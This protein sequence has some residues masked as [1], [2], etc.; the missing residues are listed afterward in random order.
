MIA[1]VIDRTKLQEIEAGTRTVH[2]LS[3]SDFWHKRLYGRH[4]GVIKFLSGHSC[5]AFEIVRI[6]YMT[7]YEV[8]VNCDSADAVI[9]TEKCFAVYLGGGGA[10]SGTGRWICLGV[11]VA[12][13]HNKRIE[14]LGLFEIETIRKEIAKGP[15]F[16]TL[17][18]AATTLK[19]HY[20]TMYRLV[21]IGEID[22]SLVAG[23]WRIPANALQSYL[24]KRHPFNMEDK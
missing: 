12:I 20:I 14:Q 23:C 24:E 5:K 4:H 17:K 3:D 10:L 6:E 19:V 9:P 13:E 16:Y 15:E 7:P 22:A 1:T 8:R 18:E 2:Y 11:I 21:T